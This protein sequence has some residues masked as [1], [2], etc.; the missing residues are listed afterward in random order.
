MHMLMTKSIGLVAH[1]LHMCE[2]QRP[3][4]C[5][6]V[7]IKSTIIVILIRMSLCIAIYIDSLFLQVNY[8]MHAGMDTTQRLII[9]VMVIMINHTKV[10]CNN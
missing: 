6:S 2:I 5:P 4:S 1:D 9:A 7:D 8:C 3:S 10:V